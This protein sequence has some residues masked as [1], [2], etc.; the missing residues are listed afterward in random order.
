MKFEG[1]WYLFSNTYI[2]PYNINNTKMTIRIFSLLIFCCFQW[3]LLAQ[4]VWPGDVNNNGV[5]SKIDLLY[6]GYAFGASGEAR[7]EIDGNWGAKNLPTDW[8]FSFPNGLNFLYADCNGDGVINEADAQIISQNVGLS[9]NDVVFMPDEISAGVPNQ[10]PPCQ[11][12]NTPTTV[13]TNQ[14]FTLDIGL[15]N[16]QIPVENLSGLNFTV[17][18]EPD[19]VGLLNIEFSFNEDSWLDKGEN[20]TLELT[21]TNPLKGEYE[22]GITKTDQIPV[23]GNG[24]IAQVSF[25]IEDDIIDLLMIDTITVIIDSITA[26]DNELNPIPIVADTL[27]LAIENTLSVNTVDLTTPFNVQFFPNPTT[28]LVTIIGT[29]EAIKKIQLY[30]HLG[31]PVLIKHTDSYME[32]IDLQSLTPQTYWLEILTES[33]V[34]TFSLSKK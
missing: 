24:S 11:F 30:N 20:Q 16:T 1:E 23:S 34:N 26:L 3:S 13:P 6:L 28:D 32:N 29:T 31:Q 22:V 17:N 33:G 18:I 5:V 14:R 10:D 25:L 27:K 15:G 2:Y 7:A 21:E 19:I 9:H 8:D 4:T 12:L